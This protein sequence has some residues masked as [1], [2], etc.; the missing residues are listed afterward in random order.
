MRLVKCRICNQ[1]W[2]NRSKLCC[3]VNILPPGHLGTLPGFAVLDCNSVIQLG[4]HPYNTTCVLCN[5]GRVLCL[6]LRPCN[7][8]CVILVVYCGHPPTWVVGL[9]GTL[10]GHTP[11]VWTK[12]VASLPS[13]PTL[14]CSR[15]QTRGYGQ[16]S[17]S[18]HIACASSL[19]FFQGG[20]RLSCCQSYTVFIGIFR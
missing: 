2:L 4:L 7:T 19:Q 6:V 11:Y 10:L 15:W 12:F 20:L 5:S 14:S 1:P 16:Y 13:R 17:L 9:V 3:I 8:S 18:T